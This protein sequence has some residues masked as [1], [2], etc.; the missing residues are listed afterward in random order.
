MARALIRVPARA[1]RGEVLEIRTLAPH[2]ME[3]GF[4]HDESGA[5]VPRNIITEFTCSYNGTEIFRVQL[6]PAISANPY[7]GFTTLAVESG[8][9]EFR[10]SGDH[11]FSLTAS[12]GIV[13]E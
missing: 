12:A 1:K 8:T 2:I 6:S 3:T 13:V 4:R 10:W 5:L 7:I 9:L 11:G